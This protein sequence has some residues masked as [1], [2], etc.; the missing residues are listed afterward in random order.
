MQ[1]QSTDKTKSKSKGGEAKMMKLYHTPN[2]VSPKQCSSRI[3][4]IIDAPLSLV[5]SV[6]RCFDK[7]QAYKQFVKSCTMSCGN[8][9]TV[10]SVRE[11]VLMSGLPAERSTERLDRL[12]DDCHVM[13]FSIIGGDHKLANYQSTTTVHHQDNKTVLIESYIVDIPVDSCREDTCFFADTIIGYNLKSL[14]KMTEK[15]AFQMR[16]LAEVTEKMASHTILP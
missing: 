6:V 1:L 8:G 14:A 3:V 13:I 2:Q 7:P 5:W 11:L 9:S 4:Q 12:D 16:S 15:M 10:G